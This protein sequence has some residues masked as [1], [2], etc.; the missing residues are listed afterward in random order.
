MAWQYAVMAGYQIISGLQQA[1]MIGMQA[2][3]QKEIDEFNAQLAEYDAWKVRG[4]GQT[5]MAR[6]QNQVDQAIAAGKTSAAA[7]GVDIN[8]GSLS[9]YAAE[10]EFA[11]FMNQMDIE[12][13]SI[14]AALGYKRQARNI[15]LG[16]SMNQM[17]SKVQQASV[18]GG[19]I[20]NAGATMVKGMSVGDGDEPK[21]NESGYQ[22]GPLNGSKQLS[23]S[24]GYLSG[25]NE[26][27]LGSYLG[28][29]SFMP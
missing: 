10:Q 4:Y 12:N 28:E 2:D 16:S 21:R 13:Q 15:R 19:S 7:A 6:Y 26:Q 18:I 25:L 11:G 24:G 27:P 22:V 9:E 20:M 23:N 3:I 5:Q 17:Q 29:Y 1:E 8:Q 14:E